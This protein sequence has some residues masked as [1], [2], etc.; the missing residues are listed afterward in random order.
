MSTIKEILAQ[1]QVSRID[2]LPSGSSK[3]DYKMCPD[4]NGQRYYTYDVEVGHPYFGRIFP[5]PTCNKDAFYRS[6]GLNESERKITLESIDTNDRPGTAKAVQAAREFI[7]KPVG[8]LSIHGNFGNGKTTILQAVVN[9]IVNSGREA[10]YLTAADLLAYLR[11]TFNSETKESDY[12][13]LNE[14]ARVPV[15]CID[16]LDKLRDTPYSRELQQELINLRY[17]DARI[18]GTVLAWNGDTNALPWQAVISRM[19]EFTV[20]HNTDSDIRKLLGT[21]G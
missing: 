3:S 4:C 17:R 8:F 18:L 1:S 5:C 13:R 16:E 15:L 12:D 2:N 11:D 7:K 14:L 19:S 21:K 9:A 6:C 10:R 20:I